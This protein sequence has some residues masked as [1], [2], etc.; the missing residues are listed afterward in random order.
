SYNYNGFKM[1]NNFIQIPIDKIQDF[2]K[3]IL[4]LRET[5]ILGTCV[6]KTNS[7]KD[8]YDRKKASITFGTH[9]SSSNQAIC[10]FAY[11]LD[12]NKNLIDERILQKLSLHICA[13]DVDLSYRTFKFGQVQIKSSI[14]DKYRDIYY[15]FEEPKLKNIFAQNE[16]LILVN[17]ILKCPEDCKDHGA[18][19]VNIDKIIYKQFGSQ[20]IEERA[21]AYLIVPPK[22][23]SEH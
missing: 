19:N 1:E 8:I 17:Q 14:E 20:H 12:E 11:D 6:L 22:I 10:M 23:S 13:V 7:L 15:G 21:I 3:D 9:Y 4:K 2:K 16:N 18:V 5:C